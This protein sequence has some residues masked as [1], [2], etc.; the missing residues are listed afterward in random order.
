MVPQWTYRLGSAS[1][2]MSFMH[3]SLLLDSKQYHTW[4]S[5]KKLLRPMVKTTCFFCME[6]QNNTRL[7]SQS[8]LFASSSSWAS[9]LSSAPWCRFCRTSEMTFGML[10][11]ILS[12]GLTSS[13]R[14]S[15][16]WSSGWIWLEEVPGTP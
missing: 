3:P 5:C 10:L 2:Q 15:G 14:R 9:R 13:Q 12:R 8:W 7:G 11:I 6:A 1:Y 16:P 4:I